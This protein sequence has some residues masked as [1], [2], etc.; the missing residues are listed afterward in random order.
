MIHVVRRLRD[1][2]LDTKDPRA[3]TIA[4]TLADLLTRGSLAECTPAHRLTADHNVLRK[5][6]RYREIL[7]LS[8][9]LSRVLAEAH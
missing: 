8:V 3:S 4:G 2:L 9:E 6:P 7:R 1:A 5:D